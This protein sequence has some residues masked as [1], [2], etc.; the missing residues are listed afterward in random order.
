MATLV[1]RVQDDGLHSVTWNGNN[2]AGAPV[3]SGV[4]MYTV[5]TSHDRRSG[6]MTLLK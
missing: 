2:D 5:I 6:K 1:D 4:Y 3:G